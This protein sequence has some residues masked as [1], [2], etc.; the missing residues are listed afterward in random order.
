[1]EILSIYCPSEKYLQGLYFI[2]KT[3]PDNK[4]LSCAKAG[5][6]IFKSFNFCYFG[7]ADEQSLL[8]R[9][10]S[11]TYSL[12]TSNKE[13]IRYSASYDTNSV[14][15]IA[16]IR[17]TKVILIWNKVFCIVKFSFVCM[18]RKFIVIHL[19]FYK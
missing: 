18:I 7:Q 14:S 5:V 15:F 12:E 2:V 8:T 4:T 10:N 17:I 9:V 6:S 1:M 19:L 11:T 3:N 16:E 13:A